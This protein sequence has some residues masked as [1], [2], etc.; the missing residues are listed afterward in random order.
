MIN[1][2]N[3]FLPKIIPVNEKDFFENLDI[4]NETNQNEDFKL[5][6]YW[7]KLVKETF[8]LNLIDYFRE[9]ASF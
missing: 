6:L 2:L 8:K 5:F 4:E 9:L 7:A 3:L 1:N